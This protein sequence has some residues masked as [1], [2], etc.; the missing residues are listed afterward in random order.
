MHTFGK[1]SLV[2][3]LWRYTLH[4]AK[5]LLARFLANWKRRSEII[6]YCV[7]VVDQSFDNNCSAVDNVEL[8]SEAKKELRRASFEAEVKASI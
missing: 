8:S 6:Q 4:R 7:D 1:I 2:R 3:Y 5:Y